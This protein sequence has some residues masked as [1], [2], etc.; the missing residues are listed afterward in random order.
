MKP[1]IA[2]VSDPRASPALAARSSIT[3]RHTPNGRM[4]LKMVV[5]RERTTSATRKSRK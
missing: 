2:P 5:C 3:C 4:S 1:A